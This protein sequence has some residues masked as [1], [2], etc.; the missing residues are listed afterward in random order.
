M[1]FKPAT[2]ACH[3][4]ESQCLF[5][6]ECLFYHFE[7]YFNFKRCWLF[8]VF[9]SAH[10]WVGMRIH[11]GMCGR[12]EVDFECPPQLPLQLIFFF[13]PHNMFSW[14]SDL[15]FSLYWLASEPPNFA[16]LYSPPHYWGY[17]CTQSHLTFMWMF[18][19]SSCLC[20][21]PLTHRAASLASEFP[22][23]GCFSSSVFMC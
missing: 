16:F 13:V 8:A 2:Y 22:Y 19:R 1:N 20:S 14:T 23:I 5:S 17:R 21:K 11:G 15:P 12:S 18:I 6:Q 3:I 10:A 4:Q 7:L 9:G